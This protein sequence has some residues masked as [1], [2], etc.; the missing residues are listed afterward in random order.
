MNRRHDDIEDLEHLAQMGNYPADTVMALRAS[1]EE[2]VRAMRIVME[3]DGEL[4]DIPHRSPVRPHR[5][6]VRPAGF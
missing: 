3:A 2:L 5:S 1:R 4:D 6:P